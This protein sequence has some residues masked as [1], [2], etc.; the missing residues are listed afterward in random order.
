MFLLYICVQKVN[1]N[2]HIY[3]RTMSDN[4]VIFCLQLLSKTVTL[5]WQDSSRH[6]IKVYLCHIIRNI[7]MIVVC[8]YIAKPQNK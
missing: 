5:G 6:L 1:N 4:D 3:C 2:M 7:S 8:T